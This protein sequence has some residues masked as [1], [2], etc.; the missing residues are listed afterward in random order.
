M[1]NSCCTEIVRLY[2]KYWQR[3]IRGG[4]HKQHNTITTSI[5]ITITRPQFLLKSHTFDHEGQRSSGSACWSMTLI[6]LASHHYHNITKII[7][8]IIYPRNLTTNNLPVIICCISTF[9]SN[10]G[11]LVIFQDSISCYIIGTS[12]NLSICFCQLT[13]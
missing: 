2:R 3:H 7:S 5:T 1:L 9:A 4:C 8:I 6:V 12:E 10:L 13:S 11:W